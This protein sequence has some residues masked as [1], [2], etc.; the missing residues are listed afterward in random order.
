MGSW[1][2]HAWLLGWTGTL[3]D[4]S[5]C[6]LWGRY[7][8]VR[9]AELW[10]LILITAN[11]NILQLWN[12]LRGLFYGAIQV[13]CFGLHIPYVVGLGMVLHEGCVLT[14]DLCIVLLLVSVFACRW[15]IG[16]LVPDDLGLFKDRV[17]SCLHALTDILA[18][19]SL[20]IETILSM[21]ESALIHLSNLHSLDVGMNGGSCQDYQD[22][23]DL[24][25]TCSLLWYLLFK[26]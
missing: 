2:L 24:C 6:R 15:S 23:T 11:H 13:K 18:S 17:I 8:T 16:K 9:I 19:Q 12:E 25:H 7:T 1:L 26:P 5:C 14:L 10:W 3:S 21:W 22:Q 20:I 4:S